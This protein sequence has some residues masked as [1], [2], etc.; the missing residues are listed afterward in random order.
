MTKLTQAITIILLICLMWIVAANKAE[1]KSL[2]VK[3]VEVGEVCQTARTVE[4]PI[5]ILAPEYTEE[6]K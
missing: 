5:V 6:E 3:L 2:Q 4:S 1:I